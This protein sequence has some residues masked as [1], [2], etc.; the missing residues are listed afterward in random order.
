MKSFNYKKSLKIELQNFE[1]NPKMD[2]NQMEPMLVESNGRTQKISRFRR[3]LPQVKKNNQFISLNFY[4]VIVLSFQVLATMARNIIRLNT[5]LF[6]GFP[7]IVIPS[8]TG[9]RKE[10]NPDEVLLI[11]SSQA[12]WIGK[13]K[14]TK[15][16]MKYSIDK[17]Y[18]I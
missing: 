15:W 7:S 8:L 10:L 6:E 5:G 9:L 17:Y 3:F 11:S 12:S 18:N 13:L 16:I 4:N 14:K 1:M 2:H